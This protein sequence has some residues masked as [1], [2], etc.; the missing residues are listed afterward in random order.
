MTETLTPSQYD[1][2]LAAMPASVAGGAA[3]G[4]VFAVP[5]LAGMAAGSLFAGLLLTVSIL[6]VPPQ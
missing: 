2:L 1:G 4:W 6:L 5:V 3:V